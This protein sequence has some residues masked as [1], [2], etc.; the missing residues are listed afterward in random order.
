MEIGVLD[1]ASEIRAFER[2]VRQGVKG[3]SKKR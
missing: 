2:M 3:T 1:G